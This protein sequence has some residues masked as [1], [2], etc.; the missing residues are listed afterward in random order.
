MIL[1]STIRNNIWNKN[2]P[3]ISSRPIT[4]CV[5]NLCHT[6]IAIWRFEFNLK[7]LNR[8]TIIVGEFEWSMTLYINIHLPS[9]KRWNLYTFQSLKR[10][11]LSTSFKF[12]DP[13]QIFNIQFKSSSLFSLHV[14]EIDCKTFWS[15]NHHFIIWP[16]QTGLDPSTIN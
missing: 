12:L 10:W 15:I 16:K 8:I 1:F 14:E 2:Q 6:W 7:D 13:I 11:N 5:V 4:V 3:K 9:L